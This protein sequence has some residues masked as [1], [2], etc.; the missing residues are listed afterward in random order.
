MGILFVLIFCAFALLALATI[1]A[2]ILRK[3]AY[4]LTRNFPQSKRA[5]RIATFF[6]YYCVVFAA[7]WFAAYALINS[8]VLHRDP[9]L[10]DSWETPLP[11]GYSLLMIDTTDQGAIRDPNYQTVIEGVRQLQIANRL[12]LGAN[13]TG[14]LDR[15]GAHSKFVDSY[16]ELNTL[17]GTRIN[18]KTLDQLRQRASGERVQL[19]LREFRAVYWDYRT[20][21]FD[22][23]AAIVLFLIPATGFILMARWIWRLRT[24]TG[25]R[26]RAGA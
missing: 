20:T 9:G 24:L 25:S 23:L 8:N 7:I 3:I 11:N 14:Y 19:H 21:W 13:D 10:G 6:P 12:I 18:F 22:Y 2:A 5:I 17:T 1:N 26:T 16:F 15:I 4:K